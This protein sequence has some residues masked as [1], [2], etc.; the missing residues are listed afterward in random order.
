M[1]CYQIENTEDMERILD[2]QLKKLQVDYID[3]YLLHALSANT[4]EKMQELDIL[5]FLDKA[6]EKGKIRYPG[7]SY[8]DSLDTFKKIIDAYPKWVVSQI[9]L[10]Y[11][12]DHYQAGLCGVAYAA[13]KGVSTVVMEPLKGGWLASSVPE[14]VIE[15][16]RKE[17]KNISLTEWALRWVYSIPEVSCILS[18]A[19]NMQ[20]ITENL[21][22]FDRFDKLDSIGLTEKEQK[23]FETAKLAFM[24][25]K[26][27][28]C[29]TCRYCLPCPAGV[30]IPGV[31]GN[32]NLIK[33]FDSAYSA[34]MRYARLVYSETSGDKCTECGKCEKACPQKLPIMQLMKEGHE[35]MV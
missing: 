13:E 1:P 4:W 32:Y 29:T 24:Q 3:F 20:Q 30:D 7:F 2:D 25:H 8:H 33:M 28:S 5:A 14:S 18:G 17:N 35:A 16:F 27:I 15:L 9:I 21:D 12:D 34:K 26:G 6:I 23:L 22:S 11:L 19:S 31:L 10:N